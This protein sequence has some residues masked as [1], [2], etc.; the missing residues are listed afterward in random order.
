M[1]KMLGMIYLLPVLVAPFAHRNENRFLLQKCFIYANSTHFLKDYVF[2]H[3]SVW[4]PAIIFERLWWLGK[5]PYHPKFSKANMTIWGTAGQPRCSSLPAVY[6]S[7]LHLRSGWGNWLWSW[8]KTK[9]D[10]SVSSATKWKG[11]EKVEPDSSWECT[12]VGQEAM[13][14]GWNA[15]NLC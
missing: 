10:L 14:T 6:F 12:V 1:S 3:A 2:A 11:I 15:G 5:I 9:R 4:P 7:R 13:D 8:D